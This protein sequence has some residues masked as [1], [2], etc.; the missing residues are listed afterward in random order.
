[1]TFQVTAA[2]RTS[3]GTLQAYATKSATNAL[4]RVCAQVF[5]FSV[6]AVLMSDFYVHS[7]GCDRCCV[8]FDSEGVTYRRRV[9]GCS[10]DEA[11]RIVAH[12]LQAGLRDNEKRVNGDCE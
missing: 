7:L 8:H 10:L 11:I 1:M 4:Q 6:L 5:A 2:Q 9:N 12:Q 3:A